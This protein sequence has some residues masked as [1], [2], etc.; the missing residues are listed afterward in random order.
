MHHG[1]I[2]RTRGYLLISVGAEAGGFIIFFTIDICRVVELLIPSQKG[3]PA[4]LILEM[5][6]EACEGS[7]LLTLMLQK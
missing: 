1:K 4:L 5:P 7:V 2:S 3:S 6:V